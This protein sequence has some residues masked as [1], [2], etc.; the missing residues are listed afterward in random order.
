MV[1]IE[2]YM[3]RQCRAG[4]SGLQLTANVSIACAGSRPK[5]RNA[6][7]ILARFIRIGLI[8]LVTSYLAQQ[9]SRGAVDTKRTILKGSWAGGNVIMAVEKEGSTNGKEKTNGGCNNE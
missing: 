8:S 6:I 9:R 5:S 3:T 2:N 7:L 4:V 1:L